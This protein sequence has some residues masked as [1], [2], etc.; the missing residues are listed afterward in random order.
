MWHA[1]ER[2]ETGTGFWWESPK[3][4][5]LLNDQG[6]DGRMGLKWIVGRLVGGVC[7]VD[8]PGSGQGSLA[9]CC[10]CG[11]EPSG[12]GATELGSQS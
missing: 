5:D 10:E 4:E 12:S 1:W 9:G 2:G 11:D 3:E 6:V 7:A 8:S